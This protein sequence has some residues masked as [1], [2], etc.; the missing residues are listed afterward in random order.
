MYKLG[1]VEVTRFSCRYWRC[2]HESF[3]EIRPIVWS[4]VRSCSLEDTVPPRVER[5]AEE[6]LIFTDA[7]D[8]PLATNDVSE[9]EQYKAITASEADIVEYSDPRSDVYQDSEL[10][11]GIL[12]TTTFNPPDDPDQI[13]DL[14]DETI[15]DDS[16]VIPD[17]DVSMASETEYPNLILRTAS[18]ED[19]D[20]D[21]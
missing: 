13:E 19:S 8:I 1:E 7:N 9:E 18:L 21:C 11:N 16:N 2:F 4:I 10:D 20:D 5:D 15:P 17:D 6:N 14:D 12:L 3:I